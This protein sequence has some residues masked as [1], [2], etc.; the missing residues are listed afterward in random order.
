M[1]LKFTKREILDVILKDGID[2]GV[3]YILSK[4]N[5]CNDNVHFQRKKESKSLISAY[6]N[7]I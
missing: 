2:S 4:I 6:Q 1:T 7:E 5:L 3:T